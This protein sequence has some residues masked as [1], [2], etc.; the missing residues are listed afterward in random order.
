[1]KDEMLNLESCCERIYSNE[2]ITLTD[3]LD[4]WFAGNGSIVEWEIVDALP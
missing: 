3:R 2:K 4:G 1:M